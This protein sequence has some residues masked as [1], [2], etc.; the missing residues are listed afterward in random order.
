MIIT[1]GESY[2]NNLY[3]WLSATEKVLKEAR[4][5]Y[6]L[7]GKEYKITDNSYP[8]EFTVDLGQGNEVEL[9]VEGVSLSGEVTRSDVKRL[10]G[11]L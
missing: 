2:I 11:C 3:V 10:A 9:W 6:K 1:L 4:L 8:F 5:H 7:E